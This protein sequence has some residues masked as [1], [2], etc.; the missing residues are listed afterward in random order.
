MRRGEYKIKEIN[1]IKLITYLKKIK[2]GKHNR[3]GTGAH[4]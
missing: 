2:D 3:M 4:K 1:I